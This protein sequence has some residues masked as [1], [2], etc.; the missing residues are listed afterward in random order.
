L[1]ILISSLL[2]PP[3]GGVLQWAL[4]LLLTAVLAL[5]LLKGGTAAIKRMF[6]R[7]R[8]RDPNID[9]RRHRTAESLLLSVWRYFVHALVLITL[10]NLLGVTPAS[11]LAS[12]GVAGIALGLGAQSLI[13]DVLAGFFILFEDQYGVGDY[14][15]V[16]DAAGTVEEIGLRVTRLRDY[17]GVLHIVPNGSIRTVANYSRG[18]M[19]ATIDMA[20][21]YEEEPKRVIET[22]ERVCTAYKADKRVVEGPKVLGVSQLGPSEVVY[23]VWAK[24][25]AGEQAPFERELRLKILESFNESNIE[26]PCPRH[27]WLNYRARKGDVT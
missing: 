12:A 4:Q 21:A 1:T 3:W 11:L 10:L 8:Q 25:T 2:P 18:S 27:V 9:P 20:V 19:R 17:S 13:Q 5:V 7:K 26:I 6:E 16:P 24:V 15:E 23:T 14:V 22:L